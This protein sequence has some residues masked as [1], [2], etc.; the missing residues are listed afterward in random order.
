MSS[1]DQEQKLVKQ[2]IIDALSMGKY[3]D[4]GIMESCWD[5]ILYGIL[6]PIEGLDDALQTLRTIY[7]RYFKHG[8]GEVSASESFN[9]LLKNSE[10]NIL[11]EA[12][13]GSQSSKKTEMKSSGVRSDGE[14]WRCCLPCSILRMIGNRGINTLDET[15]TKKIQTILYAD[16]FWSW[17]VE[18]TDIDKISGKILGDLEF[19]GRFPVGYNQLTGYISQVM[20]NEINK[21][22]SSRR[23]QRTAVSLKMVGLRIDGSYAGLKLSDMQISQGMTIALQ[24]VAKIEDF[25]NYRRVVQTI[26]AVAGKKESQQSLGSIRTSIE[27]LRRSSEKFRYGTSAHNTVSSIVWKLAGFWLVLATSKETGVSQQ[28]RFEDIVD[29]AR[30]TILS[31]KIGTTS[32]KSK[33]KIYLDCANDLTD[34]I[35]CF[36]SKDDTYW[37]TS[38]PDNLKIFLDIMEPV[39]EHFIASFKE[40]TG[41]DLTNKKWITEDPVVSHDLP[42]RL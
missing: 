35:L 23:R 18:R 3:S 39:I 15:S 40:A 32:E 9:I 28:T 37:K 36:L 13:V 29:T 33:T 22:M 21:G 2:Q 20:I 42:N 4:Y 1:T 17:F 6:E 30:N 24:L 26:E 34:I 41:I 7:N 12:S 19:G 10:S 27:L 8:Y 14:W 31:N 11:K 38:S 16:T 25:Y 5:L